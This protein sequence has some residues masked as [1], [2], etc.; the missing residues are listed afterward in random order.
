[1]ATLET[2]SQGR[3]RCR[4]EACEMAPW[5]ISKRRLP[6]PKLLVVKP[7][8]GRRP[9]Y[10]VPIYV[11]SRSGVFF[12]APAILVLCIPRSYPRVCGDQPLWLAGAWCVAFPPVIHVLMYYVVH[13]IYLGT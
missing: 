5:F 9:L 3:R 2:P 12:S 13:S 7:A 4:V 6:K 10:L 1:M 8:R 11:R